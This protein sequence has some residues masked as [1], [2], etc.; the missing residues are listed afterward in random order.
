MPF[1][2]IDLEHRRTTNILAAPL[3]EIDIHASANKP[4]RIF[5][6]TPPYEDKDA[7]GLKE[8]QRLDE[9]RRMIEHQEFPWT[10]AYHPYQRKKFY[11]LF[12]VQFD[13]LIEEIRRQAEQDL[14][15]L[16]SQQNAQQTLV[17][18]D[19]QNFFTR[20]SR[21]ERQR[22]NQKLDSFEPLTH[23][24]LATHFLKLTSQQDG[25]TF[26]FDYYNRIAD[27][28][29]LDLRHPEA[30]INPPFLKRYDTSEAQ[31]IIYQLLACSAIEPLK[32][33]NAPNT[34]NFKITEIGRNLAI[35]H[36]LRSPNPNV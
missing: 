11:T 31:P 35:W 29:S 21:V 32:H 27:L 24:L 30:D 34:Q 19:E 1:L 10:A 22:L 9:Y 4:S 26:T 8:R 36:L 13:L 25:L 15:S 6:C 33:L 7:E 14:H 28:F 12:N 20:L 17:T 16:K 23:Q 3:R 5:F 2:L 18:N